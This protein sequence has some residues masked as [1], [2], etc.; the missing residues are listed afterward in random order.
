MNYAVE[1]MRNEAVV[2]QIKVVSRHLPGRTEENYEKYESGQ[3][4]CELRLNP[5]PPEYERGVTIK[6]QLS[7]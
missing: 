1:R 6:Y 2:A 5:G 4:V 7:T 3:P